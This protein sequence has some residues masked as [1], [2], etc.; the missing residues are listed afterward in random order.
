M[1]HKATNWLSDISAD[2]LG[3]SEFRVLFHLCDCHNPSN[4]C[5]PTQGYLREVTGVSNGT[6]NNALA[7]LERK[8][9]IQRH[10][11]FDAATHRKRPTRYVLG[12]EKPK[13]E[14]PSPKIG[15]GISGKAIS[16]PV[17]KE[18][19]PIKRQSQL[20][21]AGDGA[22]SKNGG[23]P[24]PKNSKSHLQPV[25]DKPVNKPVNNPRVAC[26]RPFFTDDERSEARLV[27]DH[28]GGG[29]T[30]LFPAVRRRV[31]E[32]LVAEKMLSEAQTRLCQET[33]DER[34]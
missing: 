27:V 25:G 17:E 20:Q 23:E 30:V 28:L 6:L 1:S 9:L 3:N 5:F 2:M 15:D 32:C 24:S 13:C 16:S 19:S 4:G 33:L 29:G 21:L 31:L 12:F 22:I 7:S 8:G 18:P 11:S 14:I 10:V 26:A 34:G